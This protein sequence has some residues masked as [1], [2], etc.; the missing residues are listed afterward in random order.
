M[1]IDI[2]SQRLPLED[3]SVD[4]IIANQILEHTKNVFWIL[5]QVSRVLKP[6]GSLILGVPNL[7]ALH[8][9]VLL[10][11]GVQPSPIK[12]ASAHVRGFTKGDVIRFMELCFPGGYSLEQFSGSNFYP[13]P[14]SIARVLA[15]WFPTLAWGIFFRFE[16]V[17]TY[18]D[19]FVQFPVNARLETN[20]YLGDRQT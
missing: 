14:P 2:E 3:G 19:E 4:V 10:C 12:T 1:D 17:R 6:G 11:A 15:G 16:K 8:N 5:H 9:R 18:T 13:F 20:F 7:A